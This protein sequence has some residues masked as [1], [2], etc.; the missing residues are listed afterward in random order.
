MRTFLLARQASQ[1]TVGKDEMAARQDLKEGQV[2]ARW[3]LQEAKNRLSDVVKRTRHEGPQTIT[4][5]GR[6]AVVLISVEE[7]EELTRPKQSL[8]EFFR[9]SP[10]SELEL[11]MERDQ[12]VGREIRL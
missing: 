5:R 6:D 4:V 2:M 7:Y 1:T 8:V 10:L 11:D 9:E 3:Q 12:D